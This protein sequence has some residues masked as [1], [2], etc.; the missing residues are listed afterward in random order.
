MVPSLAAAAIATVILSVRKYF[1]EKSDEGERAARSLYRELEGTLEGP[2]AKK[3]P[4]DSCRIDIAD[5]SA[6]SKTAHFMNRMLNHD[7]YDSLVY[8][9]KINFLGPDLRQRVQAVFRR[10]KNHNKFLGIV[11]EMLDDGGSAPPRA[12]KYYKW[13]DADEKLLSA[14][15]PKMMET[16]EKRA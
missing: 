7:V 1:R 13:M 2:D 11:L 6:T 16:L 4:G 9:G 15:I 5:Q 3:S 12:D 10:I 8:S 14:E